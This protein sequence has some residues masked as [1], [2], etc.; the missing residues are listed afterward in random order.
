MSATEIDLS[1]SYLGI[2]Q[3]CFR[4]QVTKTLKNGESLRLV[5]HGYERPG[6]GYIIGDCSGHGYAP[7]E[8]SCERTK[9]YKAILE[10]MI[11]RRRADLAKLPHAASLT[12]QVKDYDQDRYGRAVKVITIGRDWCGDDARHFGAPYDTF[13]RRLKLAI[14]N[15]ESEIRHIEFDMKMLAQK[16]AEW[17]YAPETLRDH[18]T[19]K[20]DRARAT[21]EE[22]AW[23]AFCRNWKQLWKYVAGTIA[24]HK[25][26][27]DYI[28]EAKEYGWNMEKV[29]ADHRA[30]WGHLPTFPTNKERAAARKAKKE[31]A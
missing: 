1:K 11:V 2:C 13:E 7:Y 15:L 17:K 12:I 8:I 27:S 25:R 16:I 24:E 18:E 22:K 28:A 4:E 9:E 29:A 23:K 19:V 6:S 26:S 30:K 20:A 31:A 21:A 10:A 5:L 3:C 14:A